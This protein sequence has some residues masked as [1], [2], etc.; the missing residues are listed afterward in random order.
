MPRVSESVSG[1]LRTFSFWMANRSVGHPVLEGVDYSC[2]FEEPSALEQVYAI[3]ANV[4]EFDEHGQVINARHAERR[5]AQYI[6]AH[7]TGRRPDPEFED[8]E[9]ALH[10]PPPKIDPKSKD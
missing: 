2:I 5:A 9:V 10:A 8:W 4:L 6:L 7:V 1:A 3:Y